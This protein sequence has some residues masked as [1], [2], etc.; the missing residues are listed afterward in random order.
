MHGQFRFASF[1]SLVYFFKNEFCPGR[2]KTREA[3][4]GMFNCRAKL[5]FALFLFI[6]TKNLKIS[7]VVFLR[8]LTQCFA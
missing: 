3:F 7:S 2:T 6:I 4:L 8:H 1:D 5:S